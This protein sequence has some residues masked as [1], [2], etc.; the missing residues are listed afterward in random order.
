[1]LLIP[2]LLNCQS[3]GEGGN[4]DNLSNQT[5]SGSLVI[6]ITIFRNIKVLFALEFGTITIAI[7]IEDSTTVTTTDME[8]QLNIGKSLTKKLPLKLVHTTL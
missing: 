7:E 6:P 3:E 5:S 4:N 1:M 2:M 8:A